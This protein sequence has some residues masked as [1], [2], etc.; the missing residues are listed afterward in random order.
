MMADDDSR[1]EIKK[2]V[3]AELESLEIDPICAPYAE[4]DIDLTIE[5]MLREIGVPSHLT[6]YEALKV[7]IRL[8]LDDSSYLDA[9]TCRLY[10][11]VAKIRGGDRTNYRVER[12][13]RHAVE[14]AWERGD[15]DTLQSFFGN[16]IDPSRGKPTNSQFISQMAVHL[17]NRINRNT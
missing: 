16:T 17:R 12:S 8:V 13:I 4:A 6:G 5:A 7:A 2:A 3:A 1:Q 11:D 10:P 14:V 15:L 9:V